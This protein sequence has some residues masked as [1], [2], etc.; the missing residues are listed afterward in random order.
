MSVPTAEEFLQNYKN[1]SD[2]YADQDY[3]EGRL[4]KALQEFAKLHVE[5]ALKEASEKAK[6]TE[7]KVTL[8][9]TGGYVRVPTIYKKYILNSYPLDN[10]K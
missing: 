5:A 2:H 4:I 8:D 6:I 1:D 7:R 3:S 9:N 10:I